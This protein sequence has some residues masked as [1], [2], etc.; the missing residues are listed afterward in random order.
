MLLFIFIL[1]HS[2]YI[3]DKAEDNKYNTSV[4]GCVINNVRKVEKITFNNNRRNI[5]DNA[6]RRQYTFFHKASMRCTEC[7]EAKLR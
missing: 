3:S 2:N 6:D 4:P 5:D 1:I 7:R